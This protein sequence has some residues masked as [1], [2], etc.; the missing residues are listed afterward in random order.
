MKIVL[1]YGSNSRN[2]GGLYNSVRSL[3][4]S[5]LKISGMK[6]VALAHNDAYSE[7]DLPAYAPL[8]IETY[9]IAGPANFGYSKDLLDKL[10][11]IQPDIIHPQCVWMYSSYATLNYHKKNHTPYVISPRGMLDKWILNNKGW[12]KKI[13]GF[14]FEKTHLK[15]A[16]CIHALA[17]SEYKSIRNYGCKNPI[18]VIPNGINLP[19]ENVDVD[20]KMPEWKISDNR[21]VILF[22]S[23]LHPKKGIENLMHAFS[24]LKEERK[25]WKIVIAGESASKKYMDDLIKLQ[26]DLHITDDLIFVGPQFHLDKDNCFRNADAFILPSFSEG[27]PMAVL[28][29]WSYKLPVLMTEACNIP[30]GFEQRAA[31]EI[32]P[33]VGSIKLQLG[34]FF[35][36][37]EKERSQMGENGYQLVLNKFTWTAIANQMHEVY[38]WILNGGEKPSFVKLD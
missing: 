27:L 28:E 18:A 35:R 12:K 9:S 34:E 15:N 37:S 22:L 19:Q 36:L 6:P 11:K 14:L 32:K 31:I 3:G 29:A 25:H 33:E 8:P 24:E 2:S 20:L 23:R 21:K 10:A 7:K 38:K 30:E 17:L 4:Q 13:A 16:S 5:L 1:L 26:Q